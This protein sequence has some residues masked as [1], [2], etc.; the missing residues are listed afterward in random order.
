MSEETL[1]H[2]FATTGIV[3]W[4][5]ILTCLTMSAVYFVIKKIIKK[6]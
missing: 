6:L 3:F 4:C 1:M 5:G 2:M